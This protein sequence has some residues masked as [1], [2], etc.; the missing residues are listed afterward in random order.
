M[1]NVSQPL[2]QA[3]LVGE[4]I[5]HGPVLVFVADDDL[6][7]V[8]VNQRACDVLGY[9]REELLS[10]KVT[11]V[12]PF[13]ET[14]GADAGFLASPKLA[15][16]ARIKRKDGTDVAVEFMAAQTTVAGMSLYVSV[17]FLLDEPV[18]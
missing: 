7:Y 10:L 4:A 2:V 8:A 6:S 18:T 5:D 1:M 12:S 3:S 11:D 17:G 14:P 15:G 9:T 13:P 16:T